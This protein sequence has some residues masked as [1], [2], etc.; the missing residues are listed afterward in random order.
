MRVQ[1][2]V[3]IEAPP[4]KV[5][6]VVEPIERHV[7]WMADAES[8]TFTSEQHRGVGTT[9]DCLTKIGAFRTTDRM[10]VT[11]WEPERAIGIEHQGLFTGTGRFS[12][13][14]MGAGRTRFTWTEDLE[15][16][17][18]FGGPLGA[19][20]AKPMLRRVWRANLERLER[21]VASAP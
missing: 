8:I 20:A 17:L 2:G 13:R 9:F 15:F 5:W 4:D 7:D 3:T 14:N 11:E 21:L 6:Q 10:V 16:P 19:R 1:V 18:W 12:L